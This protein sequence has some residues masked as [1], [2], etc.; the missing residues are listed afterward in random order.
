M[1]GGRNA[2]IGAAHRMAMRLDDPTELEAGALSAKC[3]NARD[4]GADVGLP[5]DRIYTDYREMAAREAARPDGTVVVVTSTQQHF[6]VAKVFLGAGIDVIC[7]KPLS[8]R[9]NEAHELV[10][11]TRK[12]GLVF[13]VALNNG[14]YPMVSQAREMIEASDAGPLRVVHAAYIQDWLTKSIDTDGQKQAKWRT[15]GARRRVRL[16]HRHRCGCP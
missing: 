8:T 16:S 1:V 13:V 6:P 7:D 10:A 11:L 3:K 15:D 2:F 5:P 12:T 4:F 14:G 9:L